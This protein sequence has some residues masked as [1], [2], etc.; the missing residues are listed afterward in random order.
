MALF[1]LTLLQNIQRERLHFFKWKFYKSKFLFEKLYICGYLTTIFLN[2]HV[3]VVLLKFENVKTHFC[4]C[5]RC[6]NMPCYCPIAP[7]LT[8]QRPI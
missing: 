4:S 1:Q 6:D 3:H 2:I 5:V 7:N 8:K